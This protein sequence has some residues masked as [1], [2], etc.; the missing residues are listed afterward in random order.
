MKIISTNIGQVRTVNW[1]KNTYTTGIFKSPIE[2]AIFLDKAD[3]AKDHVVNKKHHGGEHKAC[4][5]YGANHYPFWKEK[6]PNLDWNWGMF[7]ENLTVDVCQEEEI[8]IGSV[9]KAGTATVQVTQPRQPCS[10]LGMRFED[11]GLLKTFINQT[12]SGIYFKVIEPGAVQNGDTFKLVQE[13]PAKVTVAQVFQALY[14]QLNNAQVL[15]RMIQ[16]QAMP[17]K[18]REHIATL[19]G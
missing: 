2:E 9:Y 16:H 5:L 19:V 13:D 8:F 1:K 7:G 17:A 15:E 10:T 4:Y 6:Y 11:Q 18:L 12:K 3:V 14:R